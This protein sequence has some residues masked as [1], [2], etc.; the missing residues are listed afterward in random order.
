LTGNVG[1]IY[2]DGTGSATAYAS[3]LLLAG[4]SPQVNAARQFHSN[5]GTGGVAPVTLTAPA[6]VYVT[7]TV[8]ATTPAA[9][10][11]TWTISYTLA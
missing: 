3:G 1:Y 7:W 11:E 6:W 10:T 8:L 2:D 9:H 4:A 5:T